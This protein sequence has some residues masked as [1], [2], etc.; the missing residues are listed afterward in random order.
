MTLTMLPPAGTLTF[1]FT[2][3]EGSTE[4]W[5][6]HPAAMPAAL[7]RHHALLHAAC[8]AHHGYVFQIIGDA[9]CAAFALPADA[10]AAALAAQ[11]ALRAE[12]WGPTG[13]LRVRMALHSGPAQVQPGDFTT[14]EY[15]SSLTLSRAAR[16]LSA[17]HG[18]QVILSRATYEIVADPS[19]AAIDLRDLGEHRLKDLVRPEHIYQAVAPDLPSAFPPL[20]SLDRHT[21]NLP[22]A[23]TRFIG[24]AADLVAVAGLLAEHRL[25]T[26]TGP[27]GT[28]KTRLAL[29]VA[30]DQVEASPDGV[31]FVSFAAIAD[32]ALVLPSLAHTLG[33][34]ERPGVDLSVTLMAYLQTRAVLLLLDNFEQLLPAAPHLNALCAAAPALRLLVTS[35]SPLQIYGEVTYPVRPLSLP[36]STAALTHLGENECVAL[37]LERARAVRAGFALTAD[38]AGAVVAICRQLDGL[39]LAVE[40]AAARVR[41]L[42]PQTIAGLLE[43]Q[44]PL[45]TGGARDLPARHQ[46]LRAAID[47][48]YALLSP[49]EQR[50]FARLGVF[51][52]G[53]S[54]EAVQSVVGDPDFTLLDDLAA[55]LDKSLLDQSEG[56]AGE[57]RFAMLAVIREYAREQLE[58]SGEVAAL[59]DQHAAYYV[60][61]LAQLEPDIQRWFDHNEVERDNYRAVLQWLIASGQARLALETC[62]A[63]R[64]FWENAYGYM[65]E[66]R[67][68]F[69]S[70]LALA[71]DVPVELRAEAL[72]N[73]ATLAWQQGDFE[74]AS[75]QIH[76]AI[77]LVRPAG[78]CS[79][80]AW[81]NINLARI[82]LQQGQPEPARAAAA[83]AV[84]I[85]RALANADTLG[86]ALGHLGEGA[87]IAGDE[88]AAVPLFEEVLT[89][90]PVTGP[91]VFSAS[92]W[93]HLAEISQAHGD[94]P[95]AWACLRA[96]LPHARAIGSRHEQSRNLAAQAALLAGEPGRA[97]ADWLLA[98]QLWGAVDAFYEST[99]QSYSIPDQR[100]LAPYQAALRARL[101]PAAWEAAWAEGRRLSLEHAAALIP[102]SPPAA[103]PAAPG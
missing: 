99:G 77:A 103:T 60:A 35:R 65:R 5:Q 54:L 7:E 22:I 71:A 93:R 63:L 80:L 24:R 26:L 6:Q 34:R 101:E 86:P 20:R 46:T 69:Q 102:T 91:T 36:E 3:I 70:A 19:P 49:G 52:G 12:A 81:F 39:P 92:A 61:A 11:R 27:G 47:W 75:R 82:H 25:V 44:L 79:Q 59:R 83:E 38:N 94:Y 98:V 62:I 1:L 67:D 74:A 73:A 31:Y 84:Q 13:P 30:A 43:R 21:H 53:C 66:G 57:P 9:F 23:L 8:A 64:W 37:F 89:L 45:L 78:P 42:P 100:R 97:S 87:L 88:A 4:L 90:V 50:L 10:L 32:P 40:L 85:S 55:L 18:G 15:R 14:G 95:R 28:G 2:D 72:H 48:S 33:V 96:G 68:W 58:A 16:L 56:L 29:Q 51:A 41:L 17:A 76:T